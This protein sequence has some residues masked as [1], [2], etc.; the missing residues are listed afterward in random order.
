MTS[1]LEAIVLPVTLGVVA[2][3]YA[4]VGQAGATG[5]VAVTRQAAAV[6]AVF[7]LLNSAAALV[8]VHGPPSQAS[9]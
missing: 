6:S 9:L 7:N 5:Y 3:L 8:R 2:V 1:T 4:S